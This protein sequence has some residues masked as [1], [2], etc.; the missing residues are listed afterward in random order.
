MITV[1]KV[2]EQNK[3]TAEAVHDQ[4]EEILNGNIKP[5]K[6]SYLPWILVII[7][8]GGIGWWWW[9]KGKKENGTISD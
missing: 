2:I 6:K 9:K 5:T 3:K 8:A 1:D 4:N 7:I